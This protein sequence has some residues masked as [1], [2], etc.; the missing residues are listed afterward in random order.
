MSICTQ[1]SLHG[2]ISPERMSVFADRERRVTTNIA[3]LQGF[4]LPKA[5]WA[6]HGPKFHMSQDGKGRSAAEV[7]AMPEVTLREVIHVM[8]DTH[9]HT[10]TASSARVSCVSETGTSSAAARELREGAEERVIAVIDKAALEDTTVY[11]TVESVCKYAVYVQKQEA[12]IHRY[13]HAADMDIPDS[14][15]YS[16]HL[17]PELSTEEI[18]KLNKFKPKTLGDVG[19][20]AGMSAHAATF[21]LKYIM[22]NKKSK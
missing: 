17:M 10:S 5:Q 13:K 4:V 16:A 7:L 9:A 6:L 2:V 18:E 22:K 19:L 3:A 14:I 12:D 11:D 8:C 21:M 20:I 15:I 1:A